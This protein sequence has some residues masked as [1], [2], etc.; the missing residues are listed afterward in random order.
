MR[1]LHVIPADGLGGVESA[2]RSMAMHSH[3]GCDFRLMP[4]AWEVTMADAT[5]VIVPRARSFTPAAYARALGHVLEWRPD[6]LVTSLWRSVPIA[7]AA[8]AALPRM[9]L[10]HFVH[11]AFTT[12]IVDLRLN[13]LAMR[14]A[15]AIWADSQATLTARVPP[16]FEAKARVISFV[17]E[18][19][20][21]VRPAG[22]QP[23][24]SFVSW[25][26]L[27]SYKGV[28][29][30]VRFIAELVGRGV[31][32]RFDV[33]GPDNGA[34]PGLLAERARLGLEERVHFRGPID[35]RD[36]PR[37]AAEHDF[38]LQL[39]RFEGMAMSVVE[40][41]QLGLVP[42]VT[43]VG[44]MPRYCTDGEDGVVV[45][46]PDFARAAA[47]VLAFL[48]EPDRYRTASERAA[49][50]WR[51]HALYADDVCSAARDLVIHRP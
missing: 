13:A 44:E 23:R 19:L 11:S 3:L 27:H 17:T 16:R 5:R 20:A 21:S 8:K 10:A 49:A 14:A 2:A 48:E 33:W 31:D 41:M 29:D 7:L 37:V 36:L 39:S 42:V 38:Y 18:R 30:A 46:P 9:K 34:L 45:R 22:R 15:D 35:R 26:R 25:G 32:A 50:R 4:I 24:A 40:A 47:S 28:D 51:D 43:P 6:V 12:N 1:V